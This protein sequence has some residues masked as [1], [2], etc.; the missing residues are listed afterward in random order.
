MRGLGTLASASL[1]GAITAGVLLA[2]VAWPAY[3]EWGRQALG[4][5]DAA[6]DEALYVL[7]LPPLRVLAAHAQTNDGRIDRLVLVAQ[8][9]PG[10]A[11]WLND[12]WLELVSHYEAKVL[13]AHAASA[14]PLR[15][16]DASILRNEANEQDL[17][18]F[19]I[20]LDGLSHP[21]G[22]DDVFELWAHAGAQKPL[23]MKLWVPSGPLDPI[24][25][26][27]WNEAM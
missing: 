9:R 2:G 25:P 26:L 16:P 8:V 1:P 19:Q 14:A 24:A 7:G 21:I 3:Q 15:D 27:E 22:A 10:D 18:Q 12:T 13:P 6:V 11:I 4:A 20:S 5:S 17:F 23:H